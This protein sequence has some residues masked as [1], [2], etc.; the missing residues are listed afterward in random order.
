MST[1]SSSPMTADH[2]PPPESVG[3]DAGLALARSLRFG[4]SALLSPGRDRDGQPVHTV[5][6]GEL[7]HPNCGRS[8]RRVEIIGRDRGVDHEGA[9]F[10]TREARRLRIVARRNGRCGC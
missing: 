2:T 5:I 1:G 10:A 6:L 7:R 4:L 9:H 8:C 3:R